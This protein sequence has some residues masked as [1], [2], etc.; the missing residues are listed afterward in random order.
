M[1]YRKVVG[2]DENAKVFGE[3]VKHLEM[4]SYSCCCLCVAPV[5]TKHV[6]VPAICS[7]TATKH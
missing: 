4:A 2:V 6:H 5:F 3:R 1:T 7:P